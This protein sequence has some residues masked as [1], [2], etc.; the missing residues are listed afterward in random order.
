MQVH[1]D[2]H[3]HTNAS[4]GD[5]SPLELVALAKEKKLS[6]LGITDHDTLMGVG[7]GLEAGGMY[8]IHIIPGV[9]ISAI[10]DP[11]TLHIL[12][13]FRGYPVGLEMDLEYVQKGRSDRF[14][15]IIEK[16]NAMGLK[17]TLTDVTEIAGGAQI[18]RPHIAKALMKKG[19]VKDFDEAFDNYLA[20]GKPGYVEKK[21]LTCEKATM[22]INRHGGVPVLAHPFTLKLGDDDLKHFTLHLKQYG[23][24]GIEVYYPEH[25]REQT[26]LYKSIAKALDLIL[27]GGTDYHG[28][29]R[30][31]AS[32]G[33]TGVDRGTLMT[34]LKCVE[35]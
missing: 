10:Y 32:L 28:S 24:M 33:D 12:G 16:L 5:L 35:R 25:T 31:G 23:L 22:L 17:I 14:P 8:G 13:Y 26:R 15:K 30:N 27:T 29:D 4:D 18:G 7:E 20:K 19:Y 21:K 34:L 3:A 6:A 1:A 2:L 9:E 11:G